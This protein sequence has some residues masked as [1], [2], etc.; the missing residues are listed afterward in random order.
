[1]ENFFLDTILLAQFGGIGS[2]ISTAIIVLLASYF[3]DGISVDG[4]ISAIVV[5]VVFALI[6]YFIG[7]VLDGLV[8]PLGGISLGVVYWVVDA[9]IIYIADYFLKGFSVRDFKTAFILALV[10]TA[11]QFI[12]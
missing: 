1:M 5:A 2:I 6:N 4:P 7:G 9:V 11:V 3:L 12:F 8:K 10:I